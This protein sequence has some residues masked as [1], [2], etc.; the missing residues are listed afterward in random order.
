[1]NMSDKEQEV[2]VDLTG[3]EGKYT[4]LCGEKFSLESAQHFTL[5]P[6]SYKI[7]EK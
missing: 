3:Y 2:S 4:C 5:K 6:W 7:F 1:M